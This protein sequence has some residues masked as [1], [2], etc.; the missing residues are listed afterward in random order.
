VSVSAPRW[1]L[2]LAASHNGAAALYRDDVLVS[3]IQEERL[4][5]HKRAHLLPGRPFLA[6]DALLGDAGLSVDD[7]ARVVVAPL[8]SPDAPEHRLALHPILGRLP[9]GVISHH[10]AHALSAYATSGF[11]DACV[12]VVDGMGSAIGDVPAAERAVLVDP[13]APARGTGA[14]RET[15]SI[16][17]ASPAGLVPLEKHA[18]VADLVG[19]DLADPRTPPSPFAAAASL[20]L[21]YQA[22]AQLTFGSWDAAGKVMGLA[23]YG[24]PRFSRELFFELIERTDLTRLVFRRGMDGVAGRLPHLEPWGRRDDHDDLHCDLAASV[25]AALEEGLLALVRRARALSRSPRLALAGGVFLNSVANERIIASRLFDEVFIIPAAEDSGTAIGAA[26]HGVLTLLGPTRGSRL[27]RDA[28]GPL[29]HDLAPA[30]ALAANEGATPNATPDPIG[31]AG[32]LLADGKVLGCFQ[33]RSELGPRALG[34]RSILFDPRRADG[35]HLLNARVKH[36]EAFRPFAPA[37]L[38]SRARDWFALEGDSPFMLRVCRVSAP[39]RLPA[40]THVDGTARVQTVAEDGAPLHRLIAAFDAL[41]GVPV[42][43]N[44]SFNVAGEPLVETPLDAVRCFLGTGIDALLLGDHLLVKPAR[45][46][47]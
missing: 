19:G 29:H 2:G 38:A 12:L 24:A 36:R 34:Q 40:V 13:G 14:L 3:A 4:T 28:L 5:R 44:T 1:V 22:V 30:L 35:K 10:H 43:L 11:A 47:S 45:G 39:D 32:A 18:G 21:M 8:T 23:P 15:V 6:L 20:G 42:V 7:L 46:P 31:A 25:Q 27:E 26:F 9:H 37:V 16:Y 17:Q 41:T 33:G